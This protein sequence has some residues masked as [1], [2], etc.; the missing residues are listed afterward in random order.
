MLVMSR[1]KNESLV[2]NNDVIVTVVE[3]RGDK[4]RLGIVHPRNV[5]VHRQEVHDAIHGQPLPV[6]QLATVPADQPT[7]RVTGRQASWLDWLAASLE[8]RMGVAVD[9][10]VLA[11][12]ILDATTREL[13]AEAGSR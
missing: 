13:E 1:K 2:I 9:R 4:V 7:V 10:D 3:I 5:A 11:Q 8:A 6:P 12:S